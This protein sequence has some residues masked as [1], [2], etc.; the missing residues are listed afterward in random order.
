MV[1]IW[2]L[3]PQIALMDK[4]EEA[5][6]AL[7]IFTFERFEDKLYNTAPPK[8]DIPSYYED[9]MRKLLEEERIGSADNY[10]LSLKKLN[11]FN[12]HLAKGRKPE[13]LHFFIVTP[14]WLNKFERWMLNNDLS[15]N[16][17]GISGKDKTS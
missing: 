4:A 17:V 8:E 10:K 2:I 15:T 5:R 6:D 13:R 7:T 12:I 3:K 14:E 11:Q 16:T 9:Y 1:P